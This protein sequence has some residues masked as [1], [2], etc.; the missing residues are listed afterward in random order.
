MVQ[1][2]WSGTGQTSVPH[3]APM[4]P[5]APITH[6]SALCCPSSTGAALQVCCRRTGT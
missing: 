4:V 2:G 6:P 5:P 1:L 3:G